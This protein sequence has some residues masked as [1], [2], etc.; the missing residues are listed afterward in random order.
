MEEGTETSAYRAL[1]PPEFISSDNDGKEVSERGHVSSRET[2][3]VTVCDVQEFKMQV[4][5]AHTADVDGAVSDEHNLRPAD[6]FGLKKSASSS[7]IHETRFGSS[8]ARGA[9]NSVSNTQ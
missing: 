8:F 9:V 2:N 6:L 3:A 1:T 5:L 4:N 7:D